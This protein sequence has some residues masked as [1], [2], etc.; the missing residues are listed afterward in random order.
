MKDVMGR[1]IVIYSDGTGQRGGIFVDEK[2]SNIYKLYRATRCGPD[3]RIDPAEQ[4]TFYDPGLGTEAIGAST[5]MRVYRSVR[6]AISQATGLGLTSNIIDCYA[7]IIRMWRPG[8]KIFLFGFSR[9]AYTVRCLGGVLALCGVPT[10][11]PGDLPVSHNE[12]T[13]LKIAKEA[14]KRVYQ[15]TASK[16]VTAASPQEKIYLE[17]RELLG[18][19]FQEK[20]GSADGEFSNAEPYFIGVFDTVASLANRVAIVGFVIGGLLAIA[21]TG[22]L[23]ALVAKLILEM[24]FLSIF[25]WATGLLLLAAAATGAVWYE[26]DH[27]KGPG[28]LAGH[29]ARETRHWT[30]FRMKFY[31]ARLSKRVPYA[32]HAISIDE[33]RSTFPRQKWGTKGDPNAVDPKGIRQFEQVWFAGNHSNI[34]GSYSENDSRLS[35][36]ALKWMAEAAEK[37]GLRIDWQ[38]LNLFTDALGPQH[39][40]RRSFLFK[41]SAAKPRYIDPEYGKL[42]PT[43]LQR[44]AGGKVLHYDVYKDYRPPSLE[45][46][47]QTKHFYRQKASLEVADP[48]K[49]EE[50]TKD[51]ASAT[52]VNRGSGSNQ[53]PT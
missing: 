45:N 28:P 21:A 1:N 51:L 10:K 8:D 30:E 3:S 12:K 32:R 43:V 34:G 6:N 20:Y 50:A 25:A 23:V 13:S 2:R 11:M 37:L 49:S 26:A 44:F 35:D 40:E 7:A 16:S 38:N 22:A 18:K 14:V 5:F 15:H 36:I 4:L 47:L 52:D 53:P 19:Q 39:D 29:T 41:H 42:H 48:S 24:S 31:D 33:D 27:R 46:H 9:G 17:Q